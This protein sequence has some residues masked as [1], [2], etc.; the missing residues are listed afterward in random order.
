M[1]A[2]LGGEF[3]KDLQGQLTSI[4]H[5]AALVR[6]QQL[7]SVEDDAHRVSHSGP[8]AAAWLLAFPGGPGAGEQ[9]RVLHWPDAHFLTALQTR[10]G[11]P[12]SPL[13]AAGLS[14]TGLPCWKPR[15]M[16]SDESD[17]MD[18][19]ATPTGAV[20]QTA[21]APSEEGAREGLLPPSP[22]VHG[23]GGLA[24]STAGAAPTPSHRQSVPASRGRQHDRDHCGPHKRRHVTPRGRS[25]PLCPNG[26]FGIATHDCLAA[27]LATLASRR[28][29]GAFPGPH[30]YATAKHAAIARWMHSLAPGRSDWR[31]PDVAAPCVSG[32]GLFVDSTIHHITPTRVEHARDGRS[33]VLGGLHQ[34]EASKYAHYK[35][36]MASG[37]PMAPGIGMFVPFVVTSGGLLSPTALWLLRQ[38]ARHR[39]GSGED[40]GDNRARGSASRSFCR[41]GIRLLS[42]FLHRWNAFHIHEA[43]AELAEQLGTHEEPVRDP[44]LSPVALRHFG[45]EF[46]E[47]LTP[48]QELDLA[49]IDVAGLESAAAMSA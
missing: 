28:S 18:M 32:G 46:V 33:C 7:S 1:P 39:A 23:T 29:A 30:R 40:G 13:L 21:T 3:P 42:T 43:A 15:V 38:W 27:V 35:D 24:G 44:Y 41:H 2:D 5:A 48:S 4:L 22:H 17:V 49:D 14:G 26:G 6:W 47:L 45:Q 11:V 8:G 9:R 31:V 25:L 37:G 12:L 19:E 10:L 34:E 16:M 20:S 36:E